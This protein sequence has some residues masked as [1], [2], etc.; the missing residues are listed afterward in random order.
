MFPQGVKPSRH[1]SN[2]INGINF[3]NYIMVLY[4][5]ILYNK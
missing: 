4:L 3:I 5:G 2:Q 1:K